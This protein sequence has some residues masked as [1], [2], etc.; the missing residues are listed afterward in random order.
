MLEMGT[1]LYQKKVLTNKYSATAITLVLGFMLSLGGY[2]NILPL[3]GSANQ[4]LSAKVVILQEIQEAK[5]SP[6]FAGL[7]FE[8]NSIGFIKFCDIY[9]AVYLLYHIPLVFLLYFLFP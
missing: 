1:F 3:F 8:V 6:A 7:I 5:I 4:L 9:A 2:N